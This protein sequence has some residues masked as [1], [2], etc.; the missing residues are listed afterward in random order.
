[1]EESSLGP[2]VGP[3]VR[4][5][6]GP[7]IGVGLVVAG[8]ISFTVGSTAFSAGA[9]LSQNARYSRGEKTGPPPPVSESEPGADGPPGVIAPVSVNRRPFAAWSPTTDI[10]RRDVVRP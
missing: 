2:F 5:T 3:A 7:L 9:T 1:M 10:I 4:I 6:D 8:P